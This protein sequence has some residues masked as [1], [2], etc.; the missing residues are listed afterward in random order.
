MG[1]PVLIAS[2]VVVILGGLGSVRGTLLAS[3]LVGTTQTL[4]QVFGGELAGLAVYIAMA[5]VLAFRPRGL[6][7]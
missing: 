5:A 3:L 4:G 7:Q 6:T 1:S 2:L